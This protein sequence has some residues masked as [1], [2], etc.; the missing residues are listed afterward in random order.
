MKRKFA[1]VLALL[2]AGAL[3]PRNSLDAAPD[4]EQALLQADRAAF[5]S[6]KPYP[7]L[8]EKLLDPA[9]SWT[10]SS[11]MTRNRFEV[12]SLLPSGKG[13]AIESKGSA[14]PDGISSV[15]GHS[16]AQVG[17]IQQTDGKVY[18]L[19]IWIKRPAGWN[20]LVYQAV[21]TGAPPSADAGAGTCENP[22]KR[23]PFRPRTADEREVIQ[24]YQAVERAVTAHD[25]AAWGSHIDEA[26]FAVTSNSNRPLDKATR[27]AGLDNQKVAGI[28]P[29]PLVSARMFEF[30]DVMVMTSRQ[31]PA[32]GLPLHV[33]R[34]WRKRNGAWLEMYSYQT[35]IQAASGN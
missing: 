7:S 22:C 3:G 12:L 1:F 2:V 27:M 34:V 35:T 28:A 6:G 24:A 8:N 19:R 25:F 14:V 13:L 11:G 9:F 17:V 16:Y 21:A 30:G 15:T 23:V 29:F 10:D 33:T 31:Q 5:G 20:L 32:H 4:D 26:F 18:S